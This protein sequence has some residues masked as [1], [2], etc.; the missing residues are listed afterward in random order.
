MQDTVYFKISEIVIFVSGGSSYIMPLRPYP[1]LNVS[2]HHIK[3]LML[4]FY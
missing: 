3:Q 1:A 2:L 4:R